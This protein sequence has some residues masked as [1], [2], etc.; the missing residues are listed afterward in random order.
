MA[1]K[2]L[3]QLFHL[4]TPSVISNSNLPPQ[5]INY[6]FHL[7]FHRVPSSIR[8]VR[9]RRR[10]RSSNSKLSLFHVITEKPPAAAR[11][12]DQRYCA[13]IGAVVRQAGS[14]LTSSKWRLNSEGV[15]SALLQRGTLDI[16][17][18]ADSFDYILL[19]QTHT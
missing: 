18:S 10:R 6:L 8:F 17:Y 11:V 4:T 15:V 14:E 3:L 7:C 5:T 1:F 19:R 2:Y 12:S 9:R 13:T 16:I